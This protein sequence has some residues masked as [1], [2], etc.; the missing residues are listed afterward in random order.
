VTEMVREFERRRNVII[1]GLNKVKG[2][3]VAK[4]KGAFYAFADVRKLGKPSTELAD[5][6]L[7]DAKVVTTAGVAFGQNGEGYLRISYAASIDNINE[8]LSSIAEAVG[9]LER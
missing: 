1:D 8:G 2:F 6:L 9:R 7:N 3:S 4:P 5:Y